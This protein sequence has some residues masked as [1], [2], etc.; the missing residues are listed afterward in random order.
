MSLHAQ[1]H[2]ETQLSVYPEQI[3][4]RAERLI[5]DIC[6]TIIGFWIIGGFTAAGKL[7]LQ[8]EYNG[9]PNRIPEHALY[10]TNMNMLYV[11]MHENK[12]IYIW[13][14]IIM[15]NFMKKK[16]ILGMFYIYMEATLEKKHASVNFNY[17]IK[18]HNND[19]LSHNYEIKKSQIWH[20]K[21]D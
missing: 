16:L 14:L 10:N 3:T 8:E 21:W 6:S 18:S 12:H 15:I 7:G 19:I 1:W 5:S 9:T 17:Y 20:T 2:V 11:S 13:H 4:I